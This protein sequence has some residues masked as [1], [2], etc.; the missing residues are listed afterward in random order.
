MSTPSFFNEQFI[1]QAE[2]RL[3]QSLQTF[4]SQCFENV[5]M[6]SHDLGHHLRV[7]ENAR[8]LLGLWKPS[9]GVD[10]AQFA[11][12]ILVACML[13]D[14]GL[15]ITPSE[16]HGAESRKLAQYFIDNHIDEFFF[17]SENLLRA[18]ERHDDKDYQNS[19]F[20]F[21]DYLYLFLSIS[22]DLD[23][24]GSIGA[25]R[26]L[27]I[28]LLRE[29]P[30]GQIQQ[31][32][33]KNLKGRYK[34]I[35]ERLKDLHVWPDDFNKRYETTVSIIERLKFTDIQ[36]IH[37][38]VKAELPPVELA[39]LMQYHASLSHFGRELLHALTKN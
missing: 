9:P 28:Y 11:T 4:C 19:S 3:F 15:S 14:T 17:N 36:F 35:T 5:F 33:L 16:Q 27:E 26:Y 38:S 23:A 30:M 7:W 6:P 37:Q 1:M 18:I 32:I 20:S 24:L 12:E 21:S 2:K 34:H 22:D 13:H 25:Y 39:K 8:Q 10:Q 31:N 29:V